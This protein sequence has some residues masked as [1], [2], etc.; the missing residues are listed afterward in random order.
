[1][2]VYIFFCFL[3]ICLRASHK[4]TQTGPRTHRCVKGKKDLHFSVFI[5][6]MNEVEF[7]FGISKQDEPQYAAPEAAASAPPS[8]YCARVPM[9]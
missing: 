8:R 9:K 4:A 6:N 7:H 3:N 5:K 1:M 2:P